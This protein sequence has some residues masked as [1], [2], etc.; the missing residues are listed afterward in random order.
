MKRKRARRPTL[1]DCVICAETFEVVAPMG[2][3]KTCSP[4]CSRE[5]TRQRN[6]SETHLAYNRERQR[7]I[8]ETDPADF[9]ENRDREAQKARERER[10][11]RGQAARRERQR[12]AES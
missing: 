3:A 5:L 10:W 1:R 8:R 2:M 9:A 11:R 6:R 12:E 4:E 7:R